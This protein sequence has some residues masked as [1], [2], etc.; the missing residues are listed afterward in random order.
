VSLIND[1][2]FDLLEGKMTKQKD[3]RP[4]WW[5]LYVLGLIIVGGLFLAHYTAPSPGWRTFLD[6]GIMLVG[7]GL[8]A[9]WLETHPNELLDQPAIEAHRSA[10]ESALL[11]LPAPLSPAVQVH[12]YVHSDPALIYN[13]PEHPTNNLLVNGHHHLAKTNPSLPEEGVKLFTN[14]KGAQGKSFLG[15]LIRGNF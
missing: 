11:E 12:F 4:S 5:P 7:Y 8:M 10:I 9:W 3:S 1:F 14:R 2:G 13:V 6:T 15:H